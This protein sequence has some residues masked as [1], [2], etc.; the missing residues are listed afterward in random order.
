MISVRVSETRF[1]LH[2]SLLVSHLSAA[3]FLGFR[4]RQKA[5][6]AGEVTS[7]TRAEDFEDTVRL[8]GIIMRWRGQNNNA[9]PLD[10][11]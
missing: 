7:R 8:D 11:E 2:H 3:T 4:A 9:R 6:S 1:H 5:M 10:G